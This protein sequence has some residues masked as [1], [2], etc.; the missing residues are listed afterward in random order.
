MVTVDGRSRVRLPDGRRLDVWQGGDPRGTP[1]LF[2]HGTPGG[3]LQ[4][5]LGDGAAARSGVRLVAFSRPGYGGSTDTATTL[6]SVARD[7]AA[8]A[9]S[10]GLDAFAVLGVSGGGPYAV[11]TAAILPERV[12]AVGVVAGIGPVLELDPGAAEDPAVRAALA[13][14]VDGALRLQEAATTRLSEGRAW[15][16]GGF[17]SPEML[18]PWSGSGRPGTP[19]FRGATRDSLVFAAGWD[20]DLADVSAP[21]H[22]W[23][24][25]RDRVVPLEHG[26]WLHDQLPTSTLVVREGVGHLGTLMP[27]WE[28][29]LSSLVRDGE[30]A[31]SSG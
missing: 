29:M 16:V 18:E 26:R 17:V 30:S 19:S 21:V 10:C 31:R 1:V 13:G 4:A 6:T 8:V 12:R 3:R 28:E 9:D 14:D 27:Y 2:F 15:T 7:S 5:A 11:A 20:V 23:Y 24:G 22:L 25:Q